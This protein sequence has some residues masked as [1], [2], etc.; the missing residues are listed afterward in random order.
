[1]LGL[2]SR[3]VI[4]LIFA[5]TIKSFIPENHLLSLLFP[6]SIAIVPFWKLFP[7]GLWHTEWKCFHSIQL[8]FESVWAFELKT[9]GSEQ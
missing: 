2:L 6:D 8:E 3:Y 4:K 7:R 5:R 9:I 1:M